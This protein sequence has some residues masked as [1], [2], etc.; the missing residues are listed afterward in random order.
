MSIQRRSVLIVMTDLLQYK[1]PAGNKVKRS[2]RVS[3]VLEHPATHN[4]R[5]LDSDEA[6]NPLLPL[7][8]TVIGQPKRQNRSK[9]IEE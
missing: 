7:H 3:V 4:L 1:S 5:K 2:I 9:K 8:S 6:S